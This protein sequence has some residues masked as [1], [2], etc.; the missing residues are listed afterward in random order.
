V[1]TTV[2]VR[3]S[4]DKPAQPETLWRIPVT[5]GNHSFTLAAWSPKVRDV[6]VG[7]RD[8]SVVSVRAGTVTLGPI[9]SAG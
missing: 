9:V 5:P 8:V 4:A 3:I 1:A 6:S 2:L 7:G